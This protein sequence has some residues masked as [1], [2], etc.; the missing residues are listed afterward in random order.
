MITQ[1]ALQYCCLFFFNRKLWFIWTIF[2]CL[3]AILLWL[4]CYHLCTHEQTRKPVVAQSSMFIGCPR[5]SEWAALSVTKSK[6]SYSARPLGRVSEVSE[7]RKRGNLQFCSAWTNTIK[8]LQGWKAEWRERFFFYFSLFTLLTAYFIIYLLSL[9]CRIL[10]WRI[11]HR[12][13]SIKLHL[14]CLHASS[15]P[16]F[17][18]FFSAPFLLQRQILR[19][20]KLFRVSPYT[21]ETHGSPAPFLSPGGIGRNWFVLLSSLSFAPAPLFIPPSSPPFVLAFSPG[22]RE[23]DRYQHV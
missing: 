8:V 1:N 12:W 14:I 3:T 21:R 17:F 11:L 22:R 19:V 7:R 9:C 5:V 18:F 16:F 13:A 15:R 2:T 23:A 6:A 4:Q 10:L 20:G